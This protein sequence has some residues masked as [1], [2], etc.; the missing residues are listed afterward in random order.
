[1]INKSKVGRPKEFDEQQAL[2]L[3]MGYFWSH[4]YD[5]SSLSQLLKEMKISKSS[6]Y[7]TFGSKQK[8]FERCLELYVKQQTGW[9]KDQLKHKNARTVLLDIMHISIVEIKQQGE[10]RGCLVMNS[11]EVCYKKYPDLSE[12]I[13]FQFVKFHK[14]FT[15]LIQSGQ[16]HGDI[17]SEIDASIL[18][19]IFLNTLNGLSLMIKAGADEKI[20]EDVLYGFE[21]QIKGS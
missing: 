9:I 10:I 16:K 11:A 3:A 6:F 4:G 13:K 12:L 14:L 19:S 8:I 15:Q 7:Q 5:N 20:I 17:L 1:M 2:S 21:I 18:S